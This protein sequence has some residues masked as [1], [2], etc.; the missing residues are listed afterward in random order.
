MLFIGRNIAEMT[1]ENIQNYLGLFQEK[2]WQGSV[3]F[4]CVCVCVC[5]CVGGGG[6]GTQL[7][8]R[9][10]TK[11]FIFNWMAIPKNNIAPL[12]QGI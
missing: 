6:G 10:T 9:G 12:L 8:F 4:V 11:K 2:M 1:N 3:V 5:V 7:Y